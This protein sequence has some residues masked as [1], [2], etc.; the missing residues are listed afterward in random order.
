MVFP[1]LPLARVEGLAV[2]PQPPVVQDHIE[3]GIFTG[4]RIQT[5]TYVCEHPGSII[6]PALVIPWWDIEHQTLMQ[7][8]LPALILEIVI[9]SRW[10]P[11]WS[12]AAGLH[13]PQLW[14]GNTGG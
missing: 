6:L 1:P 8:T 14:F 12:L 3:R 10:R 11:W 7:A 2:Y 4:Q 13:P 5:V 9:P